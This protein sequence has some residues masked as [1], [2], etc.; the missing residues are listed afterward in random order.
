MLPLLLL[1]AGCSNQDTQECWDPSYLQSFESPT[2]V[3]TYRVA[4]HNLVNEQGVGGLDPEEIYAYIQKVNEDFAKSGI[5]FIVTDIDSIK[6]NSWADTVW[7]GGDKQNNKEIDKQYSDSDVINIFLTDK[8]RDVNRN[9]EITKWGGQSLSNS[10]AIFLSTSSGEKAWSHELGHKFGLEHTFGEQSSDRH[11]KLEE[12]SLPFTDELVSRSDDE[13][14]TDEE[15]YYTGDYLCG[16]EADPGAAYCDID[17][18]C[19]ITCDEDV[20]DAE[21]NVF[22]PEPNIMDYISP[23]SCNPGFVDEQLAVISCFGHSDNLLLPALSNDPED[24]NF[25]RENVRVGPSFRA[26]VTTLDDA[27]DRLQDGGTISVEP[28]TYT[29]VNYAVSE[30]SFSILGLSEDPSQTVISGGN[31]GSILEVSGGEVHLSNLTMTGGFDRSGHSGSALS[32]MS[33]RVTLDNVILKDN[34]SMASGALRV[35]SSYLTMNDVVF[36]GNNSSFVGALYVTGS[37]VDISGLT[38][39]DNYSGDFNTALTMVASQGSIEELEAYGNN[40]SRDQV[41][42]V[43]LSDSEIEIHGWSMEGQA[44]DITGGVTRIDDVDFEDSDIHLVAN[45]IDTQLH[46][47][48]ADFLSTDLDYMIY[49][50]AMNLGS[51]QISLRDVS[52]EGLSRPIWLYDDQEAHI[53]SLEEGISYSLY[54]STEDLD[55]RDTSLSPLENRMLELPY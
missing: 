10:L 28:G 47:T 53:I 12:E 19:V 6:N 43:S 31:V 55:C 5:Q 26:D 20:V 14:S 34:K 1:T 33:S 44:A 52:F 18:E 17:D 13:C 49:A 4:I 2:E 9:D 23:D 51:I 36:S 32:A 27:F 40:D 37:V 15:C 46:L 3:T 7:I 48:D 54:C 29:L 21:G 30:R 38:L 50:S 45:G 42:A 8:I 24:E 35:S 22:H 41:G 11:D 25:F 39:I 16:T